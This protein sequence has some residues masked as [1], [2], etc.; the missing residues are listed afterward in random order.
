[1][2]TCYLCHQPLEPTEATGYRQVT[3]D[4]AADGW[5]VE[6]VHVACWEQMLSERNEVT[7]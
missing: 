5:S 7:Q 4:G 1:M 6:E 2:T 3:V